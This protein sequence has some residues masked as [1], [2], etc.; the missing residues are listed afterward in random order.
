MT[1]VMWTYL[2]YGSVLNID[3]VLY[4]CVLSFFGD[5][6]ILYVLSMWTY[7]LYGSVL[8]MDYVFSQCVVL[9]ST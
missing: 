3:Y 4:Q 8:N 7:L 2:F 1:Q 5:E 6:L 9:W